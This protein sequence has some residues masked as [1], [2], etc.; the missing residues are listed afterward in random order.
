MVFSKVAEVHEGALCEEREVS[1]CEPDV[2]LTAGVVHE[3]RVLTQSIG[4][5]QTCTGVN[6]EP[7]VLSLREIKLCDQR[8][9]SIIYNRRLA[10]SNKTS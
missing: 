4:A 8:L 1:V 2:E 3:T 5:E 10:R 9:A 6:N 7:F